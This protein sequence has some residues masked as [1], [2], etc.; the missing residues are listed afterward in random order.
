MRTTY[1]IS[2]LALTAAL[3]IAPIAAKADLS[4]T[5]TATIAAAVDAA[6]QTGQTSKLQA[7]LTELT[8][9]S[10][11]DAGAITDVVAQ[12]IVKDA[13]AAPTTVIAGT[14]S[15]IAEAVTNSAIVAIVAAAPGQAGTVLAEAQTALTPDLAVA[16]VTATQ[17]ALAPAAGGNNNNAALRNDIKALV[18]D[19]KA[20]VTQIVQTAE[21]ARRSTASPS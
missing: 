17:T 3:A 19:L 15:T 13:A 2:A 12:E 5:Q 9:A 1:G 20:L 11:N 18:S 21:Q 16:A 4:L 6:M 8:T 7:L 14:E 10:P